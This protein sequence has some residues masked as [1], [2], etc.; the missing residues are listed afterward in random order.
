MPSVVEVSGGF[1]C[2]R[3]TEPRGEFTNALPPLVSSTSS[4]TRPVATDPHGRL[5]GDLNGILPDIGALVRVPASRSHVRSLDRSEANRLGSGI[6]SRRG[7][8]S[9]ERGHGQRKKKRLASA[10]ET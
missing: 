6:L 7:G 2:E 8:T 3:H 5:G 10:K 1:T 9:L 4:I